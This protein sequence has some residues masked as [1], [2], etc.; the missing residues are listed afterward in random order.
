MNLFRGMVTI[1]TLMSFTSCDIREARLRDFDKDNWIK[2]AMGEPLPSGMSEL[3]GIGDTW[4][5]FSCYFRFRIDSDDLREHL[6]VNGYK[7]EDASDFV[8]RFTI[9]ARFEKYFSPAWSPDLG[10]NNK[11]YTR[12]PQ[13]YQTFVLVDFS[14]DLVHVWTGGAS[15]PG[16][17]PINNRQNKPAHTTPDPP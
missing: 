11:V 10:S 12:N 8:R 9:D 2:V 14:S 5:G 6:D 4:Q 1:V 7:E 15:S 16:P 17:I 3:A 13:G